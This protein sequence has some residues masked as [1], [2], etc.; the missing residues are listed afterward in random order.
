VTS[1]A[2]ACRGKIFTPLYQIRV[3]GGFNSVS[4]RKHQGKAE[5]S[6]EPLGRIQE[7]SKDGLD[8]WLAAF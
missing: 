7:N 8:H 6:G 4:W 1:D 3:R 5:R 2:I